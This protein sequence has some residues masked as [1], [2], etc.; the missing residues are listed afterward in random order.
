MSI[1]MRVLLISALRAMVRNQERKII[2]E[3]NQTLVAYE[4]GLQLTRKQFN[5]IPPFIIEIALCI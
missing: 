4:N 5:Y 3:K 1:C 2:Y